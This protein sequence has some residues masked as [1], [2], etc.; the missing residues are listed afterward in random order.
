MTP[1]NLIGIISHQVTSDEGHW[2]KIKLQIKAAHTLKLL[3]SNV[4]A[5]IF[6]RL[7]YS[8]FP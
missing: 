8:M 6:L 5:E 7:Y 2:S 3:N 4:L 1:K